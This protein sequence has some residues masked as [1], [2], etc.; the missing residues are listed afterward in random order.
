MASH[1]DTQLSPEA[2]ASMNYLSNA[3]L[4]D[5]DVNYR[6]LVETA[7]DI[8]FL[9]D[10]KGKFL[11][12]NMALQRITGHPPSVIL[13]S[14]LQSLVA[15]EHQDAIYKILNEA[16]QGLTYP[17]FELDVVSANG[18]RIP[19]EIHIKTVKD[20][21]GRI[22]ALRGVARD[23][24]ERKKIESALKATEQKFAELSERA[25]NGVVII[26]DGICKYANN[27]TTELLGYDLEEFKGKRFFDW[28]PS[29]DKENLAQRHKTQSTGNQ[30]SST[31]QTKVLHK[32]GS[33]KDIE[34][35]SSLIQ[36][37]GR[38]AE[39]GIIKD[40]SEIKKLEEALR[41]SEEKYQILVD[42]INEII[43][44]TDPGGKLTFISPSITQHLGYM[45][46]EIIGKDFSDIVQPDD[47]P[48]LETNLRSILE[49]NKE[50][51]E[52]QLLDKNGNVRQVRISSCAMMENNEPVGILGISS[53]ITEKKKV[54]EE[55]NQVSQDVENSRAQFKAIIDHAPNVAIQGFNK[56]GEVL[57]WNRY[58]EKLLGFSEGQVKGKTLK[59]I[60][61]TESEEAKF[62]ELLEE[63]IRT[64]KASSLLEWT[65]NKN[66]SEKKHILA[67]VFPI[68]LPGQEPIVVAMDMDITD[69]R[70]AEEKIKK[71][72]RQIE[73]FTKISAAILAIEDEKEL[74][75]YIAQAVVDISDFS[76]VLISYFI[77]EF[78]FR[79][80]IAHKGVKKEDIERVKKVEMP[81]DKYLSY[82]EQGIKLG[83]QSCYIPHHQKDILD[84]NALIPGEK[85]YPEKENSWHKDDNLLVLM[86]DT[87]G[88][89]IGMISVDDSRSGLVP[90][91]ETVRPLEIFANLISEVTQNRVLSKKI[92]ESETK[93]RELVTNI[94]IGVFR[95][96][97]RG[98][99][100]EANPA[101]VEMFGFGD[102]KEFLELRT[103]ELYQNPN[104]NG[105]FMK[106]IEENG[107]VQNRDLLMRRK[108][109]KTFWA[110]VTATAVRDDLGKII[111][112]DSV[113]E[114]I[115]E[116]KKLQEEV[117]RLS[118]I[119]ELSGLNNRRYF[120]QKLPLIIK[121]TETFRSSVALIMVDI[122]DFKPYNDTYHHLEGDEVIKEIARVI[123]QNIRNY[124]EDGWASKF[125]NEEYALNDWAARFGGDE[126]IIVLPGRDSEDATIVAERIRGVFEKISFAPKGKPLHKTVSLGIAYCYYSDGKA[127]KG[128]KKTIF[129]P[130]YEKAS[131]ELTNLADKALFEAKKSGKNKTV[132]SKTSIELARTPPKA[133]ESK[134]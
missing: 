95:G 80:I 55:L 68:L 85:N 34:F 51:H 29:K 56:N 126:F 9:V 90:T 7:P 88:E 121:A 50:L 87:K 3:D 86:R 2:K 111:H 114:D 124:K 1:E 71:M 84:Q 73:R 65:L 4:S 19:L 30:V 122:D 25:K 123:H 15:E 74:F 5:F 116:R 92:K 58:S 37:E 54:L 134:T 109:S 20:K 102:G 70:S 39:M 45:P 96:T 113:V 97:P 127:K 18:N 105:F 118:V 100:L 8:F 35:Y 13:K 83:N 27:S 38:P 32:D 75:E 62:K 120:N 79:E 48:T 61:I 112:Y 42:N 33:L 72:S 64:N 78:P 101:I 98:E 47:V 49:G 59:G 93:Y 89:V 63:V 23:I 31:F 46:E 99:I 21:K 117:K 77:D 11:L 6:T 57:F 10:L 43:F 22:A 52:L 115:T 28:F 41:R 130:D 104:D 106:E 131:T 17:Y 110:S 36:F 103:A 66:S 132:V 16:P 76:R 67:S 129:P 108:D 91:E 69:R 14:D 24:T 44:M 94:Q 60:L 82:F 119:D 53:D 128:P 125:G 26:Q 133:D 81:S 107:L 40:I 12:L